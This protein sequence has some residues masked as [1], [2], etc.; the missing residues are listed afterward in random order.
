MR[1]RAKRL[2]LLLLAVLVL[3]V[4]RVRAC[5]T[6]SREDAEA[7]LDYLAQR[8]DARTL[9]GV[10]PGHP[11]DGEWQLVG[12]SMSVVAATNLAIR[13]PESRRERAAQV[14][15]WAKRLVDED[16]RAYDVKQWGSDPLDLTRPDGHAGYLGHVVLA[17]GAACLLDA[18][19]DAALHARLVDALARRLDASPSGLIETY[20]GETYIPDNVVVV[21]GL[22]LFDRCAGTPTH[23]ATIRRFLT[24]TRARWTDPDNGLL[25][26]AP[27][28]PARGSGAAWNAF[29]LP[30]IDEDVAR[31]P[32]ARTWAS[33]GDTAFFG[34]LH[35]LRERP[36]GIDT[37]GDVDSGPLVFGVSPSATGF[38][39]GAARLEGD[40]VRVRGVLTTAELVGVSFGGRYL[41]GPLVGDAITLA[42]KTMTRWPAPPR[43]AVGHES[44]RKPP[45]RP[46][47]PT[48]RA[49]GPALP[50]ACTTTLG[51]AVRSPRPPT[52][53]RRVEEA[54]RE[55]RRFPERAR[56]T[57]APRLPTSP[58]RPGTSS[59]PPRA[60]RSYSDHS[61]AKRHDASSDGLTVT[62]TSPAAAMRPPAL[63]TPA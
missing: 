3:N 21:A 10:A 6:T 7:R 42:A 41:F 62:R 37:G 13:Y 8:I 23:A 18:P 34:A 19:R 54:P 11:F 9:P 60:S 52:H 31:E 24:A 57:S 4:V 14:S 25:R 5:V 40:D 44:R 53:R 30:F 55:G 63:I 38:M 58:R 46:R 59:P 1:R 51:G 35:G 43:R 26:F 49:R 29:Y 33:F 32:S 36:R 22:A 56:R 50:G 45:S 27:N 2:G 17:L 48:P 20:P 61:T 16:V 15:A 47:P 12:L 39:L 28:Q